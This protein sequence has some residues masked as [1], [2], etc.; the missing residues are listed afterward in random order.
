MY[1]IHFCYGRELVRK[2][3]DEWHLKAVELPFAYRETDV[4]HQPLK[5]EEELCR[6]AFVGN[7]DRA[8]GGIVRQLLR[9]GFEVDVYGHNW[10]KFLK[11]S[12]KCRIFPLVHDEAYWSALKKYR[13]QLNVFRPHNVGSHNMRTFEV[14]SVGGILLTPYSAEQASYFQ[15]DREVFFYQSFQELVDKAAYLT[16]LSFDEANVYRRQARQRCLDGGYDYAHRARFV[17]GV[18]RSWR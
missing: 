18:F 7:P 1:D 10:S 12:G 14:P 11:A 3:R 5:R 13:V 6:L 4:H 17:L 9:L 16:S 15:V 2:L 8:R